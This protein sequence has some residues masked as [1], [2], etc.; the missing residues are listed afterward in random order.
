MIWH[1]PW[2][3]WAAILLDLVVQPP[4]RRSPAR[5]KRRRPWPSAYEGSQGSATCRGWRAQAVLLDTPALDKFHLLGTGLGQP[6]NPRA[7]LAARPLASPAQPGTN[8]LD[9]VFQEQGWVGTAA[10][11]GV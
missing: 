1:A 3:P 10:G 6:D 2:P 4:H 5:W 11:P 8:A 9:R 7:R